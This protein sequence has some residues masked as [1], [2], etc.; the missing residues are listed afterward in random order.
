MCCNVRYGYI[1]LL[2]LLYS[3]L[4]YRMTLRNLILLR[5]YCVVTAIAALV[6]YLLRYLNVTSTLSSSCKVASNILRVY[7]YATEPYN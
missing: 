2:R 3:G 4:Y 7:Q 5:R 6:R 1:H